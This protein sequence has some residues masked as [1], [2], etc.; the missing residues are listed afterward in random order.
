MEMCAWKQFVIKWWLVSQFGA[1]LLISLPPGRLAQ[2]TNVPNI[3]A[4]KRKYEQLC[5]AEASDA[6]TEILEHDV[7]GQRMSFQVLS[8]APQITR[9]DGFLSAEEIAHILKIG[10]PS[11][12]PSVVLEGDVWTQM[13]Y[14]SSQTSWLDE[15]LI[16]DDVTIARINKRI[17][18]VTGLSLTSAE[19]IQ[20]AYYTDQNQ[21]KYTPHLDWG[22]GRRVD[23]DFTYV[24]PSPGARIA[25]LIVYLNT[26]E[27]G[28]A[29]VFPRLDLVVHPKPGSALL[30]FNLM[31]YTD[32][33]AAGD[34]LVMHGACPCVR[35]VKSIVTRWTHESG[36][37]Q[38]LGLFTHTK[39]SRLSRNWQNFTMSAL[40]VPADEILT[41]GRYSTAIADASCH[42]ASGRFLGADGRAFLM[43]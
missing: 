4:I 16:Q 38:V 24:S 18:S 31:P 29:T 26:P 42:D 36:N 22:V 2:V 30:F 13:D 7:M 41:A 9:I 19:A 11:L 20:I 27:E 6:R 40:P 35:G 37:E 25:T 43:S 3:E 23:R 8:V 32:G 39:L 14:R 5:H 33:L 1:Q 12:K 34:P 15:A 21:G 17:A 28:G 10:L